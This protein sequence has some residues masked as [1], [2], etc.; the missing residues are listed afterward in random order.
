MAKDKALATC[1]AILGMCLFIATASQAT[2]VYSH[3]FDDGTAPGFSGYVSLED[4]PAAVVTQSGGEISGKLLRNSSGGHPASATNL[5]ISGLPAHSSL[6][7]SF[8]LLIIDSWESSSTWFGPDHFLVK[9]DGVTIFDYFFTNYQYNLQPQNYNPP[10]GVQMW[11]FTW[12]GGTYLA[13]RLGWGDQDEAHGEMGYRMGLDSSFY[14]IP[15]TASTVTITWQ[16]DGIPGWTWDGFTGYD[17]ESWAIDQV[18]GN[19]VPLPPGW[20]LLGSGLLGLIGWRRFKQ[21]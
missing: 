14:H 6:N 1:L 13:P 11:D 4:V 5:T 21:S 18:R 10:P 12:N 7:L 17:D 19:A 3:N 16:A 2:V 20:L 8:L 15:H 9:V